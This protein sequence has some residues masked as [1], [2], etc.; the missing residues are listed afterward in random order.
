MEEWVLVLRVVLAALGGLDGILVTVIGSL[1][2]P[3]GGFPVEDAGPLNGMVEAR[4]G[5][6][7][8][9]L[10][11]VCKVLTVVGVVVGSWVT[12]VDM[13]GVLVVE[14]LELFDDFVVPGE[15]CAAEELE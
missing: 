9:L 7:H 12:V 13:F 4:V 11:M 10:G 8:F 5:G 6:F 2:L 15:V 14:G 1:C 3:G